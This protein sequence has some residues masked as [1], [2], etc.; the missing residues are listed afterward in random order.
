MEEIETR[1]IAKVSARLIPFLIVCYFIAYLDRVNVGFAALTM[2]KDLGLSASMFG[3]GSGVFFLAYF[4]FEVP[5]NLLLHKFGARR[6]IARIMITWGILS[7]AM[8]F[9]PQI[10]AATGVSREWTFYL[11]RILLGF[12]EAGFF[13]GVIFY[14]TLWFPGV[15]RARITSAF[16]AAIPLSSV[17]GSPLSGQILRMDGLYGLAGW[18]W[19][20]IVEAIPALILAAVVLGYL[21]DRPSLATWLAPQERTWLDTRLAAEDRERESVRHFSVWQVLLNPRVLAISVIYFGVVACNYVLS[22]WLPT[23]VK[24]FGVTTMQTTWITAI[25]FLVGTIGMV[26]FGRRSDARRE[27]KGHMAVALLLA[28]GGLAACTLTSDLTTTMVLISVAAF[29]IFSA[30]PLTWTF[31]TSFLTGAASAAG[32]AVINS[33]GNL[34]GFAGPYAMGYLKDHTG[35]Y[36]A[37]L[38]FSAGLALVA[39]VVVL[40]L[41]HS[42]KLELDPRAALNAAE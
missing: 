24:S 19:L 20:F 26:W 1:T 22:F 41:N 14:L 18:Q 31:P 2:N 23:M 8:A 35:G 29:G 3:F 28:A 33:L 9:I 11:V 17:I 27:R 34:S 32:I 13:P 12:A 42:P 38:L 15:Y 21:T 5:S 7:G 4:I 39:M 30:L 6:W 40:L 10:S 37:G 25:P 36:G 16:M